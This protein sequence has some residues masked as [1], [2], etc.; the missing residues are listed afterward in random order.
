LRTIGFAVSGIK[1]YNNAYYQ[2]KPF[3]FTAVSVSGARCDCRCA[4][5][6]AGLLQTMADAST[7]EKFISHVDKAIGNGCTGILVSG[8]SDH[9]GSVPLLPHIEGISYA[10]KKG[11]RVLVHTGLLDQGTADALKSANVDQ[12]LLDVIGSEKTIRSVY[13][14]DKTPDDFFNSLLCCKRAGLQMAPHL[15]IGLDY[16]SI[17]GEYHAIDLVKR[18]E[19]EH[20]VL[21]VLVP[22]RGTKMARTLPPP[23]EEVLDVFRYA[24]DNLPGCN[25]SLGCAR[26]YIYSGIL[27]KAAID[28][29]F[30]AIAYPHEE[31]IRYAQSSGIETVFYEECCSLAGF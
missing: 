29:G 22:K 5:C 10:K 14:I 28:L 1:H 25:I 7:I 19:A 9:Y 3:S 27:E 24:K 16:G 4:H 18:A 23:L 20:L 15:V 30:S 31:A 17:D 8:G 12:V 21:V 11:L 13:G 2:N 26:P 6:D